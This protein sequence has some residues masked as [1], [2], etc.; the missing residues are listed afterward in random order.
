[1]PLS[2]TECFSEGKYVVF[3]RNEQ[4]VIGY[5]SW[6]KFMS[7]SAKSALGL[8]FTHFFTISIFYLLER[9]KI[10]KTT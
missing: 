5:H 6:L 2:V 10:F 7:L 4:K 8:N 3:L 9:L 1:M